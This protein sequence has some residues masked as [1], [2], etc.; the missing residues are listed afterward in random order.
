MNSYITLV[1]FLF[2]FIDIVKTCNTPTYAQQGPRGPPGMPGLPG[3]SMIPVTVSV[4]VQSRKRRSQDILPHAIIK[5][6]VETDELPKANI[7][8]RK[9]INNLLQNIDNKEELNQANHFRPYYTFEND[10]LMAQI[11]I[12]LNDSQECEKLIKELLD[13]KDEKM[14]IECA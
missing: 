4:S 6:P 5:F 7:I 11:Y 10:K 3:S 9:G 1:A 14:S 12:N 13:N 8:A 2:A